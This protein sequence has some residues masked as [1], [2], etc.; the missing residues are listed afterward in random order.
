MGVATH[1]Q[2]QVL[3][4]GDHEGQDDPCVERGHSVRPQLLH[5]VAHVTRE[6]REAVQH[7]GPNIHTH[8][9]QVCSIIVITISSYYMRSREHFPCQMIAKLFTDN[10]ET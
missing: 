3:L 10:M 5:E 9:T 8:T 2:L 1:F 4:A 7:T 6:R